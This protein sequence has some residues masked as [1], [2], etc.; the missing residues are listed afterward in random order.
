MATVLGIISLLVVLRNAEGVAN[1]FGGLVADF[2]GVVFLGF[3]VADCFGIVFLGFFLSF[4]L[5]DLLFFW[6]TR[7]RFMTSV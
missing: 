2:F 5:L 4:L 1:S 7:E 6:E 3:L